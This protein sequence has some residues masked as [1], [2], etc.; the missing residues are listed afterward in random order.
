M[1]YHEAMSLSLDNS[2]ENS[3]FPPRNS[4]SPPRALFVVSGVD[5]QTPTEK[6][7]IGDKFDELLTGLKAMGWFAEI[8]IGVH[9]GRPL[10][11]SKYTLIFLRRYY[12]SALFRC[13]AKISLDY[14]PLNLRGLKKLNA[15]ALR[16]A[17]ER[18]IDEFRP[19]LILGVGLNEF[20]LEVA[21]SRGLPTIEIQH[22]VVSEDSFFSSKN[23]THVPKYFFAWDAA[24]ARIARSLG[25]S[26]VTVGFP[27]PLRS[28]VSEPKDQ[29]K[30]WC[31]CLSYD[32]PASEDQ[33]GLISKPLWREVL[34]LHSRGERIRF[35]LHPV[36]LKNSRD[37][38]AFVKWISERLPGV[39]IDNPLETPMSKSIAGSIGAITH[40]SAIWFEFAL[41]GRPTL[42]IDR[43]WRS[44]FT[45]QALEMNLVWGNVPP[46]ISSTDK[47]SPGGDHRIHDGSLWFSRNRMSEFLHATL[48][49]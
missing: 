4:A 9:G 12:V 37:I 36:S 42:V 20:L 32:V 35:R 5:I 10:G 38:A 6:G 47:S 14:L 39:K 11:K 48:G 2:E 15:R 43:H 16:L 31:V 30:D 44:V 41:A 13:V 18:L 33:W 25:M 23:P 49:I 29:S 3:S 27:T 46:L 8:A 45:Q 24:S 34:A 21:E 22:G 1:N 40:S 19:C 26:P 17:H 7:L 28:S